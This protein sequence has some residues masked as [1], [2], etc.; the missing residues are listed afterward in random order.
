MGVMIAIPV[1]EE[2]LYPFSSSGTSIP[3][4]ISLVFF[5]LLNHIYH[6]KL[7][8]ALVTTISV[9]FGSLYSE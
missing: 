1:Q 5:F 6:H 8:C 9:F 2:V 4:E 3:E 7:E